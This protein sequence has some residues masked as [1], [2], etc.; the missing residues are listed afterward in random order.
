MK[1]PD[2]LRTGNQ[3]RVDYLPEDEPVLLPEQTVHEQKF[4]A[5]SQHFEHGHNQCL[6]LRQVQ[7]I[8]FD[9]AQLSEELFG[10]LFHK[11]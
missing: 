5:Y 3:Q 11:C 4:A 10:K 9:C 2:L 6:I 1:L 8:R 7:Q